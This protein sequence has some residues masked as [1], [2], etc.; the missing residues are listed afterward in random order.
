VKNGCRGHITDDSRIE[1]GLM[2]L[3]IADLNDFPIAVGDRKSECQLG[4]CPDNDSSPTALDHQG[5][6]LEKTM[7]PVAEH[8]FSRFDQE[9]GRLL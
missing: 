2:C 7:S 4:R 1:D 5:T 3:R 9:M 8:R 6:S